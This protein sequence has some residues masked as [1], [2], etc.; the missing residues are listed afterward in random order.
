MTRSEPAHASM[1]ESGSPASASAPNR[2]PRRDR[3]APESAGPLEMAA[4][5][6]TAMGNVDESLG[7]LARAMGRAAA[8]QHMARGHSIFEIA[9]VLV[10]MALVV[11]AVLMVLR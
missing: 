4:F 5:D 8:R 11:G 9:A 1:H 3:S 10:M 2:L 6:Q 7:S